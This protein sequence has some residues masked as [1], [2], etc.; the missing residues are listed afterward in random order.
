MSIADS[1]GFDLGFRSE[2]RLHTATEFSLVFSSRRVLRGKN[3][4]LHYRS[5]GLAA[6]EPMVCARLGLVIT[7]K[8]SRR[9]VQRNLLKRLAREA[10]RHVRQKLPPYDLVLRLFKPVGVSLGVEE[11]R[12]LRADVEQLLIRLP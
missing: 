11:R 2:H 9:A 5:R 6:I 7:K 1:E 8:L 12:S 3:F 4:D 10:F